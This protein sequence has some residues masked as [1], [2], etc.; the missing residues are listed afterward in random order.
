MTSTNG[1]TTDLLKMKQDL[2]LDLEKS[3]M[4]VDDVSLS[5]SNRQTMNTSTTSNAN[6]PNYTQTSGSTTSQSMTPSEFGY[7]NLNRQSDAISIESS[8]KSEVYETIEHAFKNY[9]QCAM[10]KAPKVTQVK[11][12]SPIKSTINITYNS[13]SPARHSP[14][15][16]FAF[17]N[18]RPMSPD[19]SQF[20]DYEPVN[21]TSDEVKSANLLETSFDENVVYEQLKFF[22]G[23]VCEV[24]HLLDN[25]NNVQQNVTNV[26]ISELSDSLDK[27]TQIVPNISH[28]EN[29]PTTVAIDNNQISSANSTNGT[30]ISDDKSD[31]GDVL[32]MPDQELVPDSLEFDPNL[33]MYENVK[34]RKPANTYENV[35]MRPTNKAKSLNI[36]T[37]SMTTHLSAGK[38]NNKPANFTVKQLANKFE[39]SPVD[40]SPPF[41]FAKPSF[42]RKNCDTN[43]N[44]ANP[45]K[46]KN[47]QQQ[48]LNRTCNFTRSLDENAFVRE[49]GSSR[50]SEKVNKSTQQIPVVTNVLTENSP[51]RRMLN[52]SVR[53]KSLNP[54]KRLPNL[55]DTENEEC[56]TENDDV[57]ETMIIASYDIKITPTT[58]NPIS[59][60]QHNVNLIEQQKGDD[61]R[62][63][64]NNK[65]LGSFKLDRER[66]EKIKEERR[67]QLNEKFRSESFKCE[68]ENNKAKS[69]SKIELNELKD[70][71]KKISDSLQYKSKSR[72]EIYNKKDADTSIVA[73]RIRRIGTGED[74]NENDEQSVAFRTRK[75][76]RL[77]IDLKREQDGFS[78]PTSANVTQRN[79]SHIQ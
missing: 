24:N 34:L 12:K 67:H 57:D 61:E 13:V 59:L 51:S 73:N 47:P 14:Q 46:A 52:E 40:A 79:S 53:P 15:I 74:K 42:L 37:E 77:S 28:N 16:Q 1:G 69:K 48:Q 68:K 11:A 36:Q 5:S 71:D 66:I 44:S 10:S 50:S 56:K 8:P 45:P 49:F 17:T 25:D 62:S 32:M 75:F 2:T 23:A 65:V 21:V 3:K 63:S 27:T 64:T 38:E 9:E 7:Q 19:P 20:P 60:I 31:S 22:K 54:S 6:T 70:S 76:D 33:S 72:N 41:D 35:D 55:I 78:V 26:A 29:A 58:E 43:R 4:S 39:T 30:I 18:D